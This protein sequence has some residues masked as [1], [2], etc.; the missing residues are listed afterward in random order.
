MTYLRGE[1]EDLLK[2]LNSSNFYLA[3]WSIEASWASSILLNVFTN[4]IEDLTRLKRENKWNWDFVVNLSE[5]DFPLKYAK[6]YFNKNSFEIIEFINEFIKDS[7]LRLCLPPL[8]FNK[9]YFLE[10]SIEKDIF[11]KFYSN[12]IS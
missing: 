4:G 1:L 11:T 8:K 12:K 3:S 7:P 9:K 6:V 2:E 10:F 5:S